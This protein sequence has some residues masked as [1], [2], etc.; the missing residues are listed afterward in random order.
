[1][2]RFYLSLILIS[3]GLTA[4]YEPIELD[5]E[6]AGSLM[7]INSF[8]TPDSVWSFSI[9]GLL[10]P[11]DSGTGHP[12]NGAEISIW[13]NEQP[14]ALQV[15]QEEFIYKTDYYPE[16]GV[17]YRVEITAPGYPEA[18]AETRLENFGSISQ[19]VIA[20]DY[21]EEVFFGYRSYWYP[22]S[23]TISDPALLG[24]GYNLQLHAY[25][26][27]YDE[28]NDIVFPEDWYQVGLR[29]AEFTDFNL[30]SNSI[31]GIILADYGF[32]GQELH[33]PFNIEGEAWD[34]RDTVQYRMEFRF[35]S[36]DYVL[37]IRSYQDQ[38]NTTENP[39]TTPA[40][41]YSNLEGATG[42]IAGY[43]REWFYL[44]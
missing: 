28:W 39:Y 8:Y 16:T 11:L 33:Y 3:A 29:T 31:G 1:M 27:Y 26:T 20:E 17:D 43:R 15:T 5:V 6:G 10:H 37:Y 38:I 19:P 22:G 35:L 42:I 4:C 32:N 13:A 44:N 36:P 25:S 41:V 21:E 34:A 40:Q 9:S 2:K 30:F 14:I 23:I 12:V 18:S 24:Q 7:V